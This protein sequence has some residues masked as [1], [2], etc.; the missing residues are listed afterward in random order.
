MDLADA[1][2][3]L[4]MESKIRTARCHADAPAIARKSAHNMAANKART[5]EDSDDPSGFD[6]II[7]HV[8][9]GSATRVQA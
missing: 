4:K 6:Q 3:R 8:S 7:R 5:T 2:K 1:T 9:L